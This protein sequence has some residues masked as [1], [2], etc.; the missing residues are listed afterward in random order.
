M[1]NKAV[2][3]TEPAWLASLR[4]ELAITTDKAAQTLWPSPERDRPAF[5]N[6]RLEHVRQ[7]ERDA[8]SLLEAVGGDRDIVLASVW[9]HDWFQPLF[10]SPDHGLRAAA[11]AAEHLAERG[12]PPDKVQAVCFAVAAHSS[13]SS[14]IP[15]EAHEARLLWDA[16]KLAHLGAYEIL[17]R[18]LNNLALD[19]VRSLCNDPAFPERT[20]TI[21]DLAQA[22]VRRIGQEGTP[23]NR[24]Y[25]EPSRAWA[26]E[27]LQ[28]Q[29]MFCES[30]CKQVGI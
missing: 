28:V 14:F 27:R 8:L 26:A 22:K 23:V 4:R 13:E 1:R 7:V 30:L 15:P 5:F 19:R 11:W 3:T 6:Y 29:K 17:T 20:F 21:R 18:L 10:F 24:F 12:F 25:F 9:I 16:D 2:D